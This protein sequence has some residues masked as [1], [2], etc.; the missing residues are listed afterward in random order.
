MDAS[1]F[2]LQLTQAAGFSRFVDFVPSV[3]GVVDGKLEGGAL[4]AGS[5]TLSEVYRRIL[6]SS[7]VA[8]LPEPEGINAKI[9]EL[10]TRG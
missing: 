10:R 2:L 4:R 1:D 5:A 8:S 6:E 7:Q 3:S 9:A